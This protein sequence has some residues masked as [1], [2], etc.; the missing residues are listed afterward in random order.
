MREFCRRPWRS[1]AVGLAI[2][3]A[4]SAF[5]LLTGS[6]R[7]S[8][9]HVRATLSRNFRGA[10]DIL[11]RPRHSFTP[12][13][14]RRS[15]VSDNYLSGIYGGIS[16]SQYHS[17][18]R[19]PGVAVAA[20][21]ANIGV[22]LAT[23]EVRVDMQPVLN[24]DRYQLYRVSFAWVADRATSH[25]AGGTRYLYFT[26]DPFF[27]YPAGAN[28]A[29]QS[30]VEFD[31]GRPLPVCAGFVPPD[32]SGPF[33]AKAQ[34]AL[35]CYSKRMPVGRIT[36]FFDG[37][38]RAPTVTYSFEFPLAI[39]A[40]DPV[41][42]A[43][44]LRLP[45]ALISGHYLK[46]MSRPRLSCN[47]S[48]YGAK[49]ATCQWVVPVLAST[50]TYLGD[51]LS[52]TIYRLRIPHGVDLPAL[53]TA[54]GCEVPRVPCPPGRAY[55]LPRGMSRSTNAYRFITS[56]PGEQITSR[57]YDATS[58][59][60]ELLG[61]ASPT[62]PQSQFLL[63]TL[64]IPTEPH[65]T[66]IH[67]KTLAPEPVRNNAAAWS[68]NFAGAGGGG[69]FRVAPPQ[70]ED[71]QF[72]SLHEYPGQNQFYAIHGK[73]VFALPNLRVVGEFDP[74]ELPGFAPLSKVPLSTYYPPELEPADA[75]TT[76]L[77]HGEPLLPSQN[78]GGY[79]QQP[80]LLLTTL[81]AL[82]T[83]LSDRAF[84]GISRRQLRSPISVIRVRVAGVR[85]LNTLSETRIKTV[86][87]LIH[88]R[89]GLSVDITA[90]SSPTAITV[91]LP[92][93]RFGR[94]AL[95]LSEGWT[96]KGVSISYLNALDRKDVALFALILAACALFLGNNAFASVR[97]RR[98]EIGT[99]LTIG[100]SPQEVFTLV[101][102][103]LA[104]VGVAAGLLGT[105]LAAA[106]VRALSLDLPLLWTL[107]VI[108]VALGMTLISGLLAALRA[109]RNR[110]LAA[111]LPPVSFR[112]R[113][114]RIRGIGTMAL[115]NL[116]RLPGRTALGA[117]GLGLGVALLSDLVAIEEGF[118]GSL[119]GTILGNAI[120]IEVRPEDFVALGLALALSALS[121]ADVLYLNLRERR[122]EL[123][124][125][126]TLGWSDAE[127]RLLVS[128]E[129]LLL[130]VGASLIGAIAG[131]AVG[132]LVLHVPTTPLTVGAATAAGVGALAALAASSLPVARLHRLVA[133]E[134]LSA[135]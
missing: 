109:A 110:P 87:Q 51:I 78:L 114:R 131:I 96:Q 122:A 22:T 115:V 5:V 101:L 42:E 113:R 135:E 26:R 64:W 10:Y 29:S 79:A 75:Q 28:A 65:Y 27:V 38:I 55:P 119:V 125:L 130:A 23:D 71:V 116:G 92:E 4:A 36:Q 56:L 81:N 74:T 105:A 90:G 59:Y 117:C 25:Y 97:G 132:T 3:V 89:T 30:V 83:I 40:I 68:S 33:D 41:S 19:I 13:E 11:V 111:V 112:E 104:T 62:I 106:L 17:I 32:S 43:K 7:T 73:Q 70:D 46:E 107:Y 84:S 94:P 88:E 49:F 102:G 15:L 50:R 134:V 35:S 61:R 21:I 80:P 99:L 128:L 129:A 44:L 86:A 14:R 91:D 58:A 57:H 9:I 124:T 53:L 60:H 93:G 98:S 2:L 108:P 66:Q 45:Q 31:R 67:G 54:G 103:E 121:A 133:S 126:R 18:E 76:R 8:E 63:D 118:R 1:A 34:T 123:V 85:G 20:P 127:T 82:P 47:G 69:A 120:A 37:G 39:A 48:P 6:T 77:L 100:W 95:R 24:R 12:L 72:R 16:L 52:A